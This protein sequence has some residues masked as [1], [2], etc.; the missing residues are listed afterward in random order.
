MERTCHALKMGA[1]VFGARVKQVER[2]PAPAV[3]RGVAHVPH[4]RKECCHR[5]VL[6][7]AR[8]ICGAV[9]AVAC[10]CLAQNCQ[11]QTDLMATIDHVKYLLQCLR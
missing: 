3:L 1:E 4:L 9:G 11:Q 6:R 8:C 2:Q 10:D 7:C 5:R